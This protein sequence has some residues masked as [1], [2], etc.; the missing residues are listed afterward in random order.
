LATV[1]A[2][3]GPEIALRVWPDE[4]TTVTEAEGTGRPSGAVTLPVNVPVFCPHAMNRN[5]VHSENTPRRNFLIIVFLTN[6]T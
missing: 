4:S 5:N 2:P 6:L 1:K 3:S